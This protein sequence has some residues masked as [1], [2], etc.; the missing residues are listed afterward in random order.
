MKNLYIISLLALLFT[1]TSCEEVIDLDLEESEPRLVIDASMLWYLGTPGNNQQIKLSETIGFYEEG[2]E[3]VT[4]AEVIINTGNGEE[5]IF[6]HQENGIYLNSNFIPEFDKNYTLE[7]N[8]NDQLY[9]ATSSFV[10]VAGIDYIEQNNEGGFTRED[11]EVEVFFTDPAGQDNFYL[12]SF[13]NISTSKFTLE[14]YEDEFTDGNQVSTNYSNE[15]L[16]AENE[17]HIT[18]EGISEAFYNYLYILR[19]QGGN[20]GG[21]PFQSPP[22]TVKGNIVNQT[23]PENYPF[24]Y[25]RLSEVD[26]TTYI[27]Q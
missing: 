14:I 27:V 4:D 18:M 9:T 20:S 24:G 3:P 19:S 11:L 10:P 12:F 22:A 23:N 26:S 6:A 1:F 15:D 21:G 8:Y 17:I 5:F 25:F 7:I 2:V 16:A 13:S